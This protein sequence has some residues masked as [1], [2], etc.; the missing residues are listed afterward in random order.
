MKLDGKTALLTGATGG[1]GRAIAEA[2]AERGAS[3]IL[4]S[5]KADELS[6]LSAS[7]PGEGH[8]VVVAD[9]AL[10]GSA[11]RLVAEAGDVDVLVANAGL[12]GTGR[13]NDFSEEE[14]TRAL[15]VNLE[16]PMRMA[17]LITPQL[18]ERGEGHM[19][20][21]AS[22]AGKAP[23]PRTAVYNATKFGLRG[24]ALGLSCDL[25]GTK[26]GASIVSPGFIRDAGMFADTGLKAPMGIGTATP[27]RV[28]R[29][30]IKSI[31]RDKLEI[32]VA[33]RR[34]RVASHFALMSPGSAVRA[35]QGRTG[36]KA[37]KDVAAAQ[38]EKR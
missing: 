22:L 17:R 35:A 11:D 31:E 32:T 16:A 1:L 26:V 5:R 12:P 21:T 4:S 3:V 36:Q 13:I 23:S 2:L 24:F 38:Q 7:L 18:L 25:A 29:A 6:A 10:E 9:L 19:V 30:V 34:Q 20:F 37:A 8:R 15:R 28:A 27:E 33:P 14:I